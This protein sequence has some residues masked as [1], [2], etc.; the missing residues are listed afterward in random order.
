[1]TQPLD[2]VTPI[3]EGSSGGGGGPAE[4]TAET[5]SQSEAETGTST[6][7][8]AWTAQRVWQAAAAWFASLTVITNK[9]YRRGNIDMDVTTGGL[10]VTDTT[11]GNTNTMMALD[12]SQLKVPVRLRFSS[13]TSGALSNEGIQRTSFS[14]VTCFA[15]GLPSGD[16][17]VTFRWTDERLLMVKQFTLASHPPASATSTG[18]AGTFTYDS[19]YLYIC[20]ATNTWRRVAV[21]SW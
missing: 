2:D 18:V 6:T 15:G 19:N 5:V 4:W 13:N 9:I 3:S 1:M 10:T 16:T 20:V 21:S 11:G 14:T 17:N 8:R 7:R 12:D